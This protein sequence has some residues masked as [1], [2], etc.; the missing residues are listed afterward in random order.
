MLIC[1]L[2]IPF[3]DAFTYWDESSGDFTIIVNY[4]VCS[5]EDNRELFIDYSQLGNP[6]LP[7]IGESPPANCYNP[8]AEEGKQMCCP[9]GSECKPKPD[10]STDTEGT[11]LHICFTSG[12]DFCFN[13]T[14]E[15]SCNNDTAGVGKKTVKEYFGF[16]KEGV[17]IGSWEDDGKQCRAVVRDFRCYWNQSL[18]IPCNPIYSNQTACYGDEDYYQDPTGRCIVNTT[19]V[20]YRCETEGIIHV[21]W[22]A[23]WSHT[24]SE[25]EGCRSGFSNIPCA[26]IMKLTF[27]MW[28]NVIAVIVILGV[29]Y[30]LYNISKKKGRK[31][32][33]KK[34]KKK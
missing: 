24:G 15:Q 6:Q 23:Y 29:I 25:G 19:L 20:D 27:F 11:I 10:G 28:I 3:I 30:Y 18:D 7:T 14:D 4:P 17:V 9:P 34:I 13:Y 5:E 12:I 31:K 22:T 1:I 16:E 33:G 21:K 32:K 26:D 8:H 2:L